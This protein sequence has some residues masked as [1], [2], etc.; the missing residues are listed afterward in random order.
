MLAKIIGMDLLAHA[1]PGAHQRH[2]D[3]GAAKPPGRCRRHRCRLWLRHVPDAKLVVVIQAQ[4]RFGGLIDK[5]AKALLAA[6][7]K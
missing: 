7:K 3:L 1:Q 6:G 2:A 4:R 5:D